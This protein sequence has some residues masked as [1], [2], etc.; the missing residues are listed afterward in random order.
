MRTKLLII[1]A[2]LMLGGV[3]AVFAGQYLRGARTDIAELNE[4]VGVLIAQ[5]DLPRG[6]GTEELVEKG[7]VKEE[8]IPRRFVAAD[9]VSS[10][11]LI[12]NQVLAVPVSA[13]EQLTKT[14]FQY[15]SQAGLSYSVPEDLVALSVEV[16]DVTGVAGLVKP[17]D[18][19]VVYATF[20]PDGT[21]KTAYTQVVVPKA[22]VLAVGGAVT[23]EQATPTSSDSEKKASGGV[24]AAQNDS[25]EAPPTYRTVTLGLSVGAAELVVFSR[26]IGNVQL[27]LLPQ[28]AAEP[29][30]PPPVW[31]KGP[32]YDPFKSIVPR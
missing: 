5:Q 10:P 29:D 25:T 14:R 26:E 22:R 3:A 24:F 8:R 6:L 15:P 30:M 1:V 17:G 12:A 32:K 21:D 2:A 20:K 27:A 13:G 4:P 28:N 9:A 7:F 23:P 19:V 11:R 31:F 16:D 18:N